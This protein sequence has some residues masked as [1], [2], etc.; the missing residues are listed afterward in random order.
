MSKRESPEW[1]GERCWQG[2]GG[3]EQ[4]G[5]DPSCGQ[6]PWIQ[7]WGQRLSRMGD[8][9]AGLHHV[10]PRDGGEAGVTRPWGEVAARPARVR[11]LESDTHDSPPCASSSALEFQVLSGL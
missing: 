7:G 1:L 3:Q 10:C 2:G 9:T 11:R 5:K 4:L 8:L 6:R